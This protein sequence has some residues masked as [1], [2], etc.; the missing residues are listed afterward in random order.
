MHHSSTNFNLSELESSLHKIKSEAMGFAKNKLTNRS[1]SR[2]EARL[3]Y[4]HTQ[5]PNFLISN[6]RLHSRLYGK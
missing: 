3:V 4:M 6:A 5:K 2:F 1:T